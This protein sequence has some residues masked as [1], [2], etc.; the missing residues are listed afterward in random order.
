M[1][2]RTACFTAFTPGRYAYDS[3]ISGSNSIYLLT[4]LISFILYKKLIFDIMRK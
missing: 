3:A 1:V 4:F 2:A